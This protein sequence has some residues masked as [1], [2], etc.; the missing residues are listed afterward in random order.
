MLHP[1]KQS[2]TLVSIPSDLARPPSQPLP[3]DRDR[4]QARPTGGAGRHALDGA[5]WVC[6]GTAVG[7]LGS[8]Q[9]KAPITL[10][11][12]KAYRKFA[13]LPHDP[14]WISLHYMMGKRALERKR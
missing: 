10:A 1:H 5:A 7:Q 13:L 6:A 9:A 14:T 2:V 8:R 4:C 3:L 11:A 12:I